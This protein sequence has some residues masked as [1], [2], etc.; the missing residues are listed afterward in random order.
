MP[1]DVVSASIAA[2]QA[3]VTVEEIV[4]SVARQMDDINTAVDDLG[5]PAEEKQQW[6]ETTG[7]VCDKLQTLLA[8]ADRLRRTATR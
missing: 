4:Q 8:L 1:Q 2:K 3:A 5:V 6:I 7:F